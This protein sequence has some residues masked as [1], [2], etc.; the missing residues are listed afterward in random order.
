MYIN[1]IKN[2]DR[3]IER[4]R[5]SYKKGEVL[6][7]ILKASDYNSLEDVKKA[8][9]DFVNAMVQYITFAEIEVKKGIMPAQSGL[10][11]E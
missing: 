1:N 3:L 2:I 6:T 11:V 4:L 7:N 8:M 9:P 10:V 5:G